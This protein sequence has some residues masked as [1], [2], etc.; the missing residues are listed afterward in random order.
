MIYPSPR[1][2]FPQP[3]KGLMAFGRRR[4]RPKEIPKIKK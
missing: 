4:N 3:L 1:S 2:I